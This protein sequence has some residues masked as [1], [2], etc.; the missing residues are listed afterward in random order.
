[1][2][3]FFRSVYSW[4]QDV[5]PPPADETFVFRLLLDNLEVGTLRAERGQWIFS[6]S[7]D[8]KKQN[9]IKPIVDFPSLDRE[10]RSDTLWPFF[11]LRIPSTKQS[12]VRDFIDKLPTDSVD[13]GVLLREFGSRSIA[14]PFRLVALPSAGS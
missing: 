12:A 6:Y 14:N 4:L 8:F 5:E 13:E 7:E 3:K 11:A 9:Q 10:Y 1:M 2:L